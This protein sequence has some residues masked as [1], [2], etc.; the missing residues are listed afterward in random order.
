M[1]RGTHSGETGRSRTLC[2]AAL[3]TALLS[4]AILSAGCGGDQATPQSGPGVEKIWNFDEDRVSSPPKDSEV[5]GG[6]WKVRPEP[7]A[8][9]EPNALCQT[10]EAESPILVLGDATYTDFALSASFKPTSGEEAQ[11]A[12][13]V[14]RFEDEDN[15]YAVG[16]DARED[17]VTV[18]KH[19]DGERTQLARA[20]A[21]L[22]SLGLKRGEW[23]ELRVEVEGSR[24]RVLV[25][26]KEVAEATDDEFPAGKVG[27]WTGTGS[28][29]CFDRVL[30]ETS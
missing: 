25:D 24:I 22:Q 7:G 29:A 27:L 26:M 10:G 20:S 15:H 6:T 5:F 1:I 14:F 17:T 23:G 28:E 16:A 13:L 11:A 12:G 21:S 4:A 2:R 3:L 8:P 19:S 18:Y 9:T 30:T